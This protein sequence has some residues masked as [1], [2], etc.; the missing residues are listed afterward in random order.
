MDVS[1][2]YMD[3]N[4][5]FDY[6]TGQCPRT[7][8]GSANLMAQCY[9]TLYGGAIKYYYTPQE[10][11]HQTLEDAQKECDLFSGEFQPN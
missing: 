7:I 8:N 1:Q 9:W 4:P 5:Q 2:E 3:E 10:S 6:K 11:S